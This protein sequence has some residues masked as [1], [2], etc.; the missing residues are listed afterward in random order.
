MNTAAQQSAGGSNAGAVGGGGLYAARTRNAG[1]GQTSIGNAV[2]S[3]GQNLSRAAVGT[4]VKSADLGQANQRAALGGLSGLYGE[5]VKGGIGALDASNQAL[6]G[7]SS[8]KANDPWLQLYLQAQKNVQQG[9]A[10]AG[11]G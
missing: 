2:R 5:D 1:A 11:G 10:V 3:S 6:S 8:S 9:E 4:E 7:A